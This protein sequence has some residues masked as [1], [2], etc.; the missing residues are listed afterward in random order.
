MT[1]QEKE[2]LFAEFALRMAMEE[3]E[4]K[5]LCNRKNL[6]TLT[7][8]SS[9]VQNTVRL[10]LNE[11]EKKYRSDCWGW[12]DTIGLIR[13]VIPYAVGVKR[14]LHHCFETSSE[15]DYG[16]KKYTLNPDVDREEAYQCG[17]LLID[18]LLTYWKQELSEIKTIKE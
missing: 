16:R 8:V 11:L 13:K 9:Y 18:A 3:K 4:D 12:Y 2:E 17:K 14:R 15:N 6:S 5:S 7:N 1:E 10:E